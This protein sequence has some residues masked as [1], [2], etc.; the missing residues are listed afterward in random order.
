MSHFHCACITD[1]SCLHCFQ[2][3][4]ENWPTVCYCPSSSD[5]KR[6]PPH[7]TLPPT[8]SYNMN[9]EQSSTSPA[10][11]GAAAT[12]EDTTG[13]PPLDS[14]LKGMTTS[15]E[16][17]I[18]TIDTQRKH[19]DNADMKDNLNK[20]IGIMPIFEISNN[21][22]KSSSL[23]KSSM[24]K[25]LHG[26]MHS[27]ANKKKLL[28]ELEETFKII[29]EGAKNALDDFKTFD[30][31]LDEK[32]GSLYNE[33][34]KITKDWNHLGNERSAP[35]ECFVN[36]GGEVKLL[37]D[38]LPPSSK[39]PFFTRFVASTYFNFVSPQLYGNILNKDVNGITF[40][41]MNCDILK[42]VAELIQNEIMSSLSSSKYKAKDTNKSST[43]SVNCK[44][45][46][47]NSSNNKDGNPPGDTDIGTATAEE[48][49]STKK[50]K[51]KRKSTPTTK[52][53]S[54]E[55]E[56]KKI[57]YSQD[58]KGLQ[59][60][61]LS[62]ITEC[63]RTTLKKNILITQDKKRGSTPV[64]F[65]DYPFDPPNHTQINSVLAQSQVAGMDDKF[66]DEIISSLNNSL[67]GAYCTMKIL[68]KRVSKIDITKEG[69]S[70]LDIL[71]IR[72][73][74]N[75][76]ILLKTHASNKQGE[77]DNRK[78]YEH[79]AVFTHPAIP[80]RNMNENYVGD[81]NFKYLPFNEKDPY[82]FIIWGREGKINT[83]N[84]DERRNLAVLCH[85]LMENVVLSLGVN[86]W[87]L[88]SGKYKNMLYLNIK[89]SLAQIRSG[90]A[91][92]HDAPAHAYKCY[93]AD[94]T[95]DRFRTT[96]VDVIE[97]YQIIVDENLNELI[98]LQEKLM[99]NKNIKEQCRDTKLND[100]FNP[101]DT[102]SHG[103]NEQVKSTIKIDLSKSTKTGSMGCIGSRLLEYHSTL[104]DNMLNHDALCQ[105]FIHDRA[106]ANYCSST[107]P[108]QSHNIIKV[109]TPS[110]TYYT[111]F[112][113]I[114]SI[115]NPLSVA[116]RMKKSNQ[117][118]GIKSNNID[119]TSPVTDFSHQGVYD[120]LK[121]YL[122]DEGIKMSKIGLTN[123]KDHADKLFCTEELSNEYDKTI[124][125]LTMTKNDNR[126]C[127]QDIDALEKFHKYIRDERSYITLDV[128]DATMKT[129]PHEFTQEVKAKPAHQYWFDIFFELL[130]F[131][132]MAD[133]GLITIET[134]EN[135]RSMKRAKDAWD[136]VISI[137]NYKREG[138]V[139][140][141]KG[142]VQE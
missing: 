64:Q 3:K 136:D 60:C 42:D 79:H 56:K 140:E 63:Y 65:A 13:V 6:D 22:H 61:P 94:P 73:R 39:D 139:S 127:I 93:G 50:K 15:I 20:L 131:K 62:K 107:K 106:I 124:I 83:Y 43:D 54:A 126:N 85:P 111:T 133:C 72:E 119:V 135:I 91:Y 115:D 122:D 70:L 35:E 141:G 89:N 48:V 38:F 66:K 55:G 44:L 2:D 120:L 99:M 95:E 129:I 69:E 90:N 25:I 36:V 29:I 87:A 14:T 112:D 138:N 1:N 31:M 7:I 49:E 27:R 103:G 5:H 67:G 58:I 113:T 19:M 109:I 53:N 57:R 8:P 118:D 9:V 121:R 98:S 86:E 114:D 17:M 34:N 23:I 10:A 123:V 41:D 74:N 30:D 18:R 24:G 117:E 128:S 46:A 80:A 88:M 116:L 40:I 52:N 68:H 45:A 96:T 108:S 81:N 82:N 11:S 130:R 142:I 33:V 100:Y 105:S 4:H 26:I 21:T 102:L 32:T 51:K 132:R 37:K 104:I 92:D 28:L 134:Y 47:I 125:A 59:D 101:T 137:L 71:N 75:V 76:L 84:C 12:T 16:T 97:T 110:K 78:S 77:G